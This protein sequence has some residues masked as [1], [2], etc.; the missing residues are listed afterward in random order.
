MSYYVDLHTSRRWLTD[1]VTTKLMYEKR[2]VA[3]PFIT[4]FGARR[5]IKQRALLFVPARLQNSND[6]HDV[7]IVERFPEI[8]THHDVIDDF[9]GEQSVNPDANAQQRRELRSASNHQTIGGNNTMSA[10]RKSVEGEIV[11]SFKGEHRTVSSHKS[12]VEYAIRN[13]VQAAKDSLARDLGARGFSDRVTITGAEFN[14]EIGDFRPVEEVV[15][16]ESVSI[17]C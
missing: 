11:L 12:L 17:D 16:A 7:Y 15:N 6:S 5:W 2:V 13:A 8:I 1:S 9:R 14:G 4:K 3:G 10:I